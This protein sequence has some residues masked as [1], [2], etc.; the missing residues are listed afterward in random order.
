MVDRFR[1]WITI[2]AYAILLDV[3]ATVMAY[4][5]VLIFLNNCW[6]LGA[7][8]GIGSIWCIYG[9]IGV[10]GTYKR[11]MRLYMALLKRNKRHLSFSSFRD[12]MDVPCHRM[13]VRLVLRDIGRSFDYPRV[14][15]KYYRWPWNRRPSTG[16]STLVIFKTNEEWQTWKEFNMKTM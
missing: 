1:I 9:G 6:V 16:T 12:Y 13:I 2:N 7:C 3:V 8:V 4:A 14:R 15:K 5:C 11:K 10:H